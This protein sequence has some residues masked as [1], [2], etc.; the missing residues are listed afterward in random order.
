MKM[1]CKG[2]IGLLGI[3]LAFGLVFVACD[4]S[5]GDGGRSRDDPE[6]PAVSAIADAFTSVLEDAFV[7]PSF[8]NSN[9][10]V[11]VEAL[12]PMEYWGQKDSA[13]KTTGNGGTIVYRL[14]SSFGTFS[15]M[16][17]GGATF[18]SGGVV[19]GK[20]TGDTSHLSGNNPY[21]FS[22]PQGGPAKTVSYP[23]TVSVPSGSDN[24]IMG[25][26]TL[27]LSVW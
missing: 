5:N 14:P 17:G 1:N 8:A 24:Q 21:N 15:I 20:P 27:F 10:G 9:S 26:L 23:Y 3:F 19:W 13:Y 12:K 6:I 2:F 25:I 22:I 11:K 7:D 18:V 16:T 4:T